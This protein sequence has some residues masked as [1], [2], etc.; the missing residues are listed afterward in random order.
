MTIDT[1][2]A[3]QY[4]IAALLQE[5][6]PLPQE[7]CHRAQRN[8]GALQFLPSFISVSEEIIIGNAT[9]VSDHHIR[10]LLQE[11][12]QNNEDADQLLNVDPVPMGQDCATLE[13]YEKSCPAHGDKMFH[14][15]LTRIQMNPGQILR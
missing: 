1:P 3:P 14:D 11:Y 15:F 12:Q 7:L 5:V 9:N 2:N 13:K 6:T 10:D 4:N 8:E